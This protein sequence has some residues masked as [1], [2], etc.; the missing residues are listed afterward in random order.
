MIHTHHDAQLQHH[1]QLDDGAERL[2]RLV[3]DVHDLGEVVAAVEVRLQLVG[4]DGVRVGADV[5]ARE[6]H[7]ELVGLRGPVDVDG[8]LLVRAVAENQVLV[9]VGFD[10]D[11]VLEV[12]AV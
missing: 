2:V 6:G 11:D 10:R 9:V 3:E 1:G 8:D 12:V 7:V 5:A 4:H